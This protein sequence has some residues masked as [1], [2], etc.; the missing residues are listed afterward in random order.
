MMRRGSFVLAVLLL[1]GGCSGGET[2]APAGKAS[3]GASDV[4]AARGDAE[5]T[6]AAGEDTVEAAQGS[7]GGGREVKDSNELFGFGYAYPDA[8]GAIPG[9]QAVLDRR[10]EETRASLAAESRDDRREAK[11]GDFPYRPHASDTTWKVVADL[12]SWL[13]LSSENY[14]YTGGAHGMS[15]FDSLLWDKRAGAVRDPIDLFTSAAA[16]RAPIQRPFCNALDRERE[17][18]RGEPVRHGADDMFSDCINPLESTLIL[19]SSNGRTFDRIGI[20]IA[21]YAAGPYAEG[22][23]EIT[24]PVT[25]AVLDAVKPGYK[26]SFSIGR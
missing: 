12:P 8:A 7:P 10:L 21:P 24:L 14:I 9:L 19:G 13:S 5:A 3:A 2:D 20:L 15:A 23:Y 25:Q 18:R 1:A 6:Q 11:K 26:D 16:L 17:K 22:T 4:V